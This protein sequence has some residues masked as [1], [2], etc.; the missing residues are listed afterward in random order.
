[1]LFPSEVEHVQHQSGTCE[2]TVVHQDVNE[3]KCKRIF[4][5]SW[6]PDF[7]WV[8][9]IRCNYNYV[10]QFAASWTARQIRLNMTMNFGLCCY[11]INPQ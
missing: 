3:L 10:A 1:M 11:L 6:T 4:Q 8:A 9:L 7:S 2:K 5:F